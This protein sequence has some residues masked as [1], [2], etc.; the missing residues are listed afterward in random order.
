AALERVE[1]RQDLHVELTQANA[2]AQQLERQDNAELLRDLD[3]PGDRIVEITDPAVELTDLGTLGCEE[4]FLLGV[5]DERSVAHDRANDA[6]PVEQEPEP[7]RIVGELL[8]AVLIPEDV[9]VDHR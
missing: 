1:H 7:L 5:A 2:F 3:A 8:A 6:M 4:A 9:V